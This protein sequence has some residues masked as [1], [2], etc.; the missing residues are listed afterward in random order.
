MLRIP[1]CLHN[2]LIDGGKV[3]RLA[4]RLR[5]NPQ[6]Y[7]ISFSSTQIYQWLSKPQGLVRLKGLGN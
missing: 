2:R 5:S 3:V 6:K 7:F 1:H 4:R